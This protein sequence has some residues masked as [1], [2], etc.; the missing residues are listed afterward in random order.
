[1]TFTLICIILALGALLIFLEI[2]FIPG[3]TLFGVAGVVS[4]VAGVIMMYAYFG[5][6]YGHWALVC[7][8]LLSTGMF[9]AGFKAVGSKKLSVNAVIES[10]VNEIDTTD[11]TLGMEGKAVTEIKPLGKAEFNHKI[12]EVTS[13]G[14]FIILNSVILISRITKDKIWV[15]EKQV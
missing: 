7:S 13:E 11:L 5:A 1:M 3:T 10:K 6:S 9:L 4:L 12:Y 2:F 8:I 15:Q 14:N